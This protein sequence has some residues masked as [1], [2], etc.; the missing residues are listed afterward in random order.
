MNPTIQQLI[1]VLKTAREA[2]GLSQ[3]ALAA[4]LGIPQSHLS[5]IETGHVNLKLAS[6]VEMARHLE[7]EV[8]LVP[9]QEITLVESIIRSKENSRQ[10]NEIKPAYTLD[11][12]KE[13]ED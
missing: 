13:G 10:G 12:E 9:R 3:Q 1:A 2:K 5:K 11:N 6:F 7:L 4:K 8:L